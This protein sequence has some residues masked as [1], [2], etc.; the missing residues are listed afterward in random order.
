MPGQEVV[1]SR[2]IGSHNCTRAA[3]DHDRST[4]ESI[5]GDLRLAVEEEALGR[6]ELRVALTPAADPSPDV[7]TVILARKRRAQK[8]RMLKHL[9][10]LPPSEPVTTL[11]TLAADDEDTSF[12]TTAHTSDLDGVDA[13]FD[14]LAAGI[15]SGEVLFGT[16]NV[17]VNQS[18]RT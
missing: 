5:T 3:G 6:F 4:D 15:D 13:R 18:L 14:L 17:D 11:L 1:P 9:R 10:A 16:T 8:N 7:G 2:R 12:A